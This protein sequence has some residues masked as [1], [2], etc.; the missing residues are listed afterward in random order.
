MWIKVT[1]VVEQGDGKEILIPNVVNMDT[2][3]RIV[4]RPTRTEL[5][6]FLF[7]DGTTM[8]VNGAVTVWAEGME[9]K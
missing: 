1:Q 9:A 6:D 8:T 2:V 4:P 5:S 7:S 3:K